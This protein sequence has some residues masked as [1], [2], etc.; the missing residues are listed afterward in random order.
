MGM[1][2]VPIGRRFFGLGQFSAEFHVERVVEGLTSGHKL[3][4]ALK[5]VQA[6]SRWLAQQ[7]P[8]ARQ[9]DHQEEDKDGAAAQ[10][11]TITEKHLPHKHILRAQK[12]IGKMRRGFRGYI[13][14]VSD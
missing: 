3:T 11:T 5:S 9:I 10:P 1:D 6:A 12:S 8:H 2:R 4:V 7:W 14:P 13:P